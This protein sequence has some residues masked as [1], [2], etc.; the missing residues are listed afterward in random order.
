MHDIKSKDVHIVSSMVRNS[1]S[2]V[3]ENKNELQT[4]SSQWTQVTGHSVDRLMGKS[5][6]LTHKVEN[7]EID[8]PRAQ[9]LGRREL[10]GAELTIN[11]KIIITT[12]THDSRGDT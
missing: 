9:E 8:I 11:C 10:G 1:N 7:L 12:K 4:T 3:S 6:L 2:D 5:I